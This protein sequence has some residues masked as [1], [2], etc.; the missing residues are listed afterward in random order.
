MRAAS[1]SAPDRL[2]HTGL[3]PTAVLAAG[4]LASA[5]LWRTDPHQPGHL[6]PVCP[7]R[8]LTGWQ[9][10]GC[11]GTR[12]AYDLMHG[13]VVGAWHDNA[14]L[15]LVLPLLLWALVGWAVAGWRG[16]AYRLT[17]PRYGG[18]VVL[19]TAL[20]WTVLRNAV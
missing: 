12:L 9:C 20:A 2:R 11:G 13:D 5:Y 4:V 3:A 14:L 15:L 17:L 1:T 8:Y 19:V 10:P 6:L 18:P 7:F 16:R